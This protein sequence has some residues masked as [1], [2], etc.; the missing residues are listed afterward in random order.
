MRIVVAFAV[1][2]AATP[3]LAQQMCG[4]ADK[5]LQALEKRY[6]ERAVFEGEISGGSILALYL[7][8]TTGSWT[9]FSLDRS[10]NIACIGGGGLK[11]RVI[12][13]LHPGEPT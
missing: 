6:Q 3:A 1:L 9:I 13:A 4:P 8:Q 5:V 12:E 2:L 7:N 11:S 10:A